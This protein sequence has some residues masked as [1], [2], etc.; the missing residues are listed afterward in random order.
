MLGFLKSV[1]FPFDAAQRLNADQ[2]N[3]V[4]TLQAASKGARNLRCRLFNCVREALN[5]L[6]YS[7][8]NMAEVGA[9]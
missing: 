5:K 7:A 8:S 4:A 3:A 2:K 9:R 1:T 6:S